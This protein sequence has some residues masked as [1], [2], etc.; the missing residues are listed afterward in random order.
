MEAY[1]NTLAD[2]L[3]CKL[4]GEEVL[5]LN[6]GGEASDFVRFNQSSIRQAGSVR[7]S[8][9]SLDLILGACHAKGHTS[10]TGDQSEDLS[11]L[12]A[13]L[14]DVRE[15]LPCLPED[16][17]LLYATEVQSTTQSGE[18]RLP[19]AGTAV[20]SILTAGAGLDLVGVY[21]SGEISH[22]FANSLGQRN[23]FSSHTFNLDW[24]LYHETDKAVKC[25]YA[26]FDWGQEQFE[27]KMAAA[28]AQLQVI[29]R[30]PRTIP[31]GKYWV[32]MA[33]AAV[34]DYLG[35]LNWDGFGLKSHRTKQTSLLK[36]IEVGTRLSPV[37]TLCENTRDGV[38][39]NFQNAGFLKP[40]TVSLID[41]G[42]HRNCL[43]SPRSAKEYGVATN[44]AGAG[45]GAESLEM[46]AGS[47][48][49][50]EILAR[51]DT[52]IYINNIWYLNY[53]DRPAGRITGMTRF[54]CF[55]VENGE[56]IA[57]LNVM[58]FDE[59]IF[60]AFGENL[61]GLTEEREML[62]DPETYDGR[63]TSSSRVPGALIE[64]FNFNL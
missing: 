25:G 26:G 20:D 23:W 19:E 9:I 41:Q 15:M 7:D 53:S 5:T 4:T 2:A 54:A 10:L 3:T 22:G 35:M 56:I 42:Q 21:A 57:P 46:K 63:S 24:S 34:C 6:F 61:I 1:F 11:R 28:A 40:D 64:D 55:W 51:L 8:S 52:G 32:Y 17:H 39:A 50:R 48:P 60:H 29:K 43:I 36:M 30:S 44:G 58:R 49:Q 59:T 14:A 37:V 47:I 62:L 13:L 31:P 33:P 27:V 38:A 18:N 45:E 16:P 12:T